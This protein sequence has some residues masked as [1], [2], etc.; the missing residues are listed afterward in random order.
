MIKKGSHLEGVEPINEKEI[1][2]ALF[3]SIIEEKLGIQSEAY[4]Y[5][6]SKINGRNLYD[7]SGYSGSSTLIVNKDSNNI[8]EFVIKIQPKNNYKL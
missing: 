8:D 1:D 5:L 7:K 4:K 6:S 3:L 2:N